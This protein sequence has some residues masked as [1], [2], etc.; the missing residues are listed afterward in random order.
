MNDAYFKQD[1]WGRSRE[2][3]FVQ[4]VQKAVDP[5]GFWASRLAGWKL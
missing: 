4:S 3:G 1:Y 5:G 2:R